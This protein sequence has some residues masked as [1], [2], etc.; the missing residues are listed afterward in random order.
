MAPQRIKKL[1]CFWR[2]RSSIAEFMKTQHYTQILKLSFLAYFPKVGLCDLHALCVSSWNLVCILWQLSPAQRRTSL[3]S[4][5]VYVYP[6]YHC[7]ATGRLRVSFLSVLGN[8][9]VNTF[10]RQLRILR[11]VVF[12]VVRV[13]SKGS[14]RLVLPRTFCLILIS[15]LCQRTCPETLS[16]PFSNPLNR[17]SLH[18]WGT[19][20]HT[21]TEQQVQ[22]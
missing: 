14:R 9:S 21:H 15:N 12:Y 19:K 2:T 18:R 20:F 6:S 3:P 1:I 11:G 8:G 13:V 17:C 10:P 5:C 22:L 7:Q 16:I 4:M